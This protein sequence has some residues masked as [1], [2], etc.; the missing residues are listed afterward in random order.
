MINH[1]FNFSIN[2]NQLSQTTNWSMLIGGVVRCR[3]VQPNS[4]SETFSH[5]LIL[6]RLS[7][8]SCWCPHEWFWQL[9]WSWGQNIQ[10]HVRVLASP[11]HGGLWHNICYAKSVALQLAIYQ[12]LCLNGRFM[13]WSIFSRVLL[14]FFVMLHLPFVKLHIRFVGID[15]V[16]RNIAMIIVRYH[17]EG[18]KLVVWSRLSLFRNYDV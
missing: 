14:M 16:P 17:T 7:T 8:W 10:E 6:G 9:C 2:C 3:L 13:R 18:D 12:R 15:H 5:A 11:Q 1:S 4:T